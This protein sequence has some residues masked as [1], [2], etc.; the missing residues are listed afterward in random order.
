MIE[1]DRKRD[2]LDDRKNMDMKQKSK[3][4][5]RMILEYGFR[6]G[7]GVHLGGAL[8]C[9]DILNVLYSNTLNI[10][11]TN[12]N[13][14]DRDLFILSKGHACLALYVILGSHGFY[15]LKLLDSFM[16]NGGKFGGHPEI[17]M[18]PGV[19]ATTGSLGHGLSIGIGFSL[20]N[21]MD[22]RNSKCFVLL[23][24][25]ECNEGSVWEAALSAAQFKLSNIIA[26]IDSNKMQALTPMSDSKGIK[27]E[28][29]ADKFSSF[30]WGV[31]EV[32]GHNLDHLVD[33]FDAIPFSIE[34]PSAVVAH[35]IKGKGVSFMENVPKWHCRPMTD[36]EFRIA[37]SE[38]E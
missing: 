5:R 18:V 34:K 22:N 37:L 21:R 28:P 1:E 4:L 17:R 19:E 23:G 30:G 36:D 33:V 24:D 20:A 12:V 9:I 31:R 2:Y 16:K 13:D 27:V 11:S 26:V 6:G 35:T 15:D 25:G 29:L 38:L 10:D 8:S 32:D 3:I 14:P 7:E